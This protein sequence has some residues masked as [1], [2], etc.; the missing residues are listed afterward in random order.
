MYLIVSFFMQVFTFSPC[1]CSFNLLIY[2]SNV[3]WL[4]LKYLWETGYLFLVGSDYHGE[5]ALPDFIVARFWSFRL[6]EFLIEIICGLLYKSL[7]MLRKGVLQKQS[8]HT[9]SCV[10]FHMR[11]TRLLF[12]GPDWKGSCDSCINLFLFCP[13]FGDHGYHRYHSGIQVK[14]SHRP[15]RE[16]KTEK[17][18]GS[19]QNYQEIAIVEK[20]KR[21]KET[22]YE[23]ML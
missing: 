13:S 12:L 16:V 8:N 10:Y 5:F 9:V 7:R 22:L 19:W 1:I 18:T 15:L 14:L 3:Q 20:G 11:R 2:S 4:T 17:M 21:N 6:K 23:F